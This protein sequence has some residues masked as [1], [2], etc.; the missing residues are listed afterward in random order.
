VP[1][2]PPGNADLTRIAAMPGGAIGAEA[3]SR[4]AAQHLADGD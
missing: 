3:V 1:F 4:G 2:A